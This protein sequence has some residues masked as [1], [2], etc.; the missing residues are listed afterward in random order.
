[1]SDWIVLLIVLGIIAVVIW[2][3]VRRGWVTRPPGSFTGITVYHDWMN[4]DTQRATEV[5]IERQADK[6]E[7]ED[8]SGEPD[9]DELLSSADEDKPPE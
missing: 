9:F 7:L 5:V 1:M 2:I 6:K 3:A 4:Q 8:D